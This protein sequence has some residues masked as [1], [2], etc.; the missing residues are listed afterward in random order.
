MQPFDLG[1]QVVLQEQ[2]AELTA[3]LVEQLQPLDAL[4]M[5]PNLL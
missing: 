3:L 1:Y 2:D 4:R 5:K